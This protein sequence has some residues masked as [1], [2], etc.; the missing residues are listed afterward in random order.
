MSLGDEQGY[1]ALSYEWGGYDP[2]EDKNKAT[3]NGTQIRLT[4]NL[5]GALRY[6][7]ETRQGSRFWVDALCINQN[8]LTERAQQV[9]LM[10]RIYQKALLVAMW[11]SERQDDSDLAID[12]IER[13]ISLIRRPDLELGHA[14]VIGFLENP[15][16]QSHL[17]A[18]RHLCTRS[19]RKRL[20]IV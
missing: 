7:R 2:D 6:L 19:Y 14:E 16:Y 18:F 5:L 13:S 10:S 3:V 20:W 12:L 11:I 8:D 4:I 17:E 9:Q 15:E 1:I